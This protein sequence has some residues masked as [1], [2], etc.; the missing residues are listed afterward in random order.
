MAP[1]RG[2]ELDG[3]DS[4]LAETVDRLETGVVAK[5]GSGAVRRLPRA[6]D[7][8][9]QHALR[10]HADVQVRGLAGD[11]EVPGEALADHAL[12]GALLD[13]VRL[14]VRHAHEAQP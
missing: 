8:H 2:P 10:L 3:R 12:G 5:P 6:L 1:A 7:A 13:L 11:R 4:G 9:R 14:L